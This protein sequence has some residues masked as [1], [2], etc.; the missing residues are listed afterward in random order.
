MAENATAVSDFRI[1]GKYEPISEMM[2]GLV[3][4]DAAE[5]RVEAQ[6]AL[7]RRVMRVREMR[8]ACSTLA[9]ISLPLR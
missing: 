4:L 8:D 7:G 3:L 6:V 1:T 5:Q 9:T 2:L